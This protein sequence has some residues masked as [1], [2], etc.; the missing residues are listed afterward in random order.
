MLTEKAKRNIT[1]EEIKQKAEDYDVL[2]G[3]YQEQAKELK[4]T[5][6]LL[7]MERGAVQGVLLALETLTTKQS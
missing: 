6:E 2:I 7:L 5:K 1:F 3:Y 4:E